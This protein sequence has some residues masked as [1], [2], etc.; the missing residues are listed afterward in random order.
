[1]TRERAVSTAEARTVAA[2]SNRSKGRR[3]LGARLPRG[4]RQAWPHRLPMIGDGMW[5][6]QKRLPERAEKLSAQQMSYERNKQA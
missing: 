5:L 6:L 3:L 4:S 1:M 2:T